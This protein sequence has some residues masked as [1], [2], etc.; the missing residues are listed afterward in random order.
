M[1]GEPV[2]QV[3]VAEKGIPADRVAII[4]PGIDLGEYNQPGAPAAIPEIGPEHRRRTD[5]PDRWLPC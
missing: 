2:R 4:Y 3:A 1:L 5:S